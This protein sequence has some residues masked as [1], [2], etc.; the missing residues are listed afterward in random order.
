VAKL[1]GGSHPQQP[2]FANALKDDSPKAVF[3]TAAPNGF[4]GLILGAP[5]LIFL[6][7]L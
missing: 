6:T 2:A 4:Q 1:I 5:T 7:L 3:Q